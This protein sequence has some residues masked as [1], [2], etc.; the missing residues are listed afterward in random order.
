MISYQDKEVEVCHPICEKA[1]TGALEKLGLSHMYRV[2]H[3]IMA[4][5]LE[6]DFGIVNN[7][8][9]KILCVIEVKRTP[10]AVNSSR[11]QYQAMSYIQ[12]LRPSMLERPFYILTNLEYSYLFRYDV[13]YPSAYQQIIEPGLRFNSLFSSTEDESEYCSRVANH[14][15]DL[16]KDVVEDKREYVKGVEDIISSLLEY[17]N[18]VGQWKSRFAR[19]AYEYI[20]GAFSLPPRNQNLPNIRGYA[21]RLSALENTFRRID[22]DGI[23]QLTAD[24]YEETPHIK[25][26]VLNA[27]YRLG[28]HN[29]DADELV[30]HLHQLLSRGHEQEGEV[31]TDIELARVM[32][33]IV[34][35]FCPGIDGY[36]CDPAAGSGNLL[37]NINEF[38]PS[39]RPGQI[40]ANDINPLL[41]QLL[42]LRLGLKFPSSISQGN[43]PIVST[44]DIIDLTHDYFQDVDVIIMN[45]PMVAGISVRQKTQEIYK[46]VRALGVTPIT[47]QGPVPLEMALLELLTALCGSKTLI[48]SLIPK[49][50][51]TGLGK[52]DMAFRKFLIES[53]GLKLI[54][55]YPGNDIFEN[56]N[57]D[58]VI[59]V[60]KPH[61]RVEEISFLSTLT[62]IPNLDFPSLKGT[63]AANHD[64]EIDSINIKHLLTSTLLNRVE[65]WDILYPIN[66]EIDEFIKKY[67][68]DSDCFVSLGSFASKIVRGKIGN[69]GATRLSFISQSPNIFKALKR[70]DRQSLYPALNKA[71]LM[72][73]EVGQGDEKYLSFKELSPRRRSNI[74]A[75]YLSG[76]QHT[77]RQPKKVKTQLELVEIMLKESELI[78]KENT[79]LI[80]RNL[81]VHGKAYRCSYDTY[82]STNFLEIPM[83]DE[84]L[85]RL[86]GSWC[87]TIFYQLM[88]ERHC[89]NHE[90]ARKMESAQIAKTRVPDLGFVK[91]FAKELL[92]RIGEFEY[93]VTLQDP[94]VRRVDRVWASFLFGDRA[95]EALSEAQILLMRAANIR[96]PKP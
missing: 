84:T 9:E 23:F 96:N 68:M 81:R 54:F 27:A 20:R 65:C 26:E 73:L 2:R 87:T 78:T 39:L 45:P 52:S 11:Y 83:E 24:T 82:V 7:H 31:P 86:Y 49:T 6:M 34:S 12:Q 46:R 17:R 76:P 10:A 40:K 44:L 61:E 93:F 51:L 29:V 19:F 85:S 47:N 88:C 3:H 33:L 16:L 38:Y 60:G 58:T 4:G 15:A 62:P 95:E 79:I 94:Q 71:T 57:R 72:A 42:T 18:N 75:Q 21:Q 13:R 28:H 8:T 41:L 50:H 14:F 64:C 55:N 43:S 90:G 69:S 22:F 1:L 30:T 32:G 36:V 66:D 59:I 77:G 91:E 37:S 25:E 56:V 5:S 74:I 63:L 92:E 67:Q 70:S 48:C 35:H 53:F 89:K 80:P